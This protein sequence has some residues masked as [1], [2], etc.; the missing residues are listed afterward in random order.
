MIRLA[1][2]ADEISPDLDEGIAVL[3]DEGIKFI[4]LRSVWDTNVLDLSEFQVA[5]IRDALER[6]GLAVAAIGS[7][8]GKVPIDLP[9][10][11]MRQ[12]FARTLALARTLGTSAIRVFSYYPPATEDI[13]YRDTVIAR[14]QEFAAAAA[15]AGVT[16][17]HEN[18]TGLYGDTI[19]HCL[20]VLRSVDNPH[21]QAAFDP[22]NFIVSGETPFPD[23]FNALRPWIRHVHVKDALADG[24]ITPAGGGIARWPEFL[25]ALRGDG[26]DGFLTLEPHL[27]KGGLYGGF[28]GPNN[29]RRASRALQNLLR[30]MGWE[31]G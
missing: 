6:A 22:A 9:L 24:T 10:D 7:P 25:A 16:L 31:Y 4:E 29:F 5:E 30:Q 14:L 3:R 15:E 26:Y 12:R 17:F 1:A 11:A 2:F 18:D 13:P 19:E 20:D 8:I 21:C 28:S 27:S 23:A